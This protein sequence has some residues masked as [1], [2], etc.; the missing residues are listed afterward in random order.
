MGQHFLLTAAART[1]SLASVA[2]MSD[3]EARSTFQRIRWADNGGEPYCPKCGSTEHLYLPNQLRWKCRGCRHQYSVTSSTIF[4]NRKLPVRDYLLAIA[5]FVNGA[6]GYAALQL[7]RDLDCQYK[8][9][10]V[11]SHKLREAIE[12]E[13]RGVVLA[14]TVEVDGAYFGGHVRQ[15]NKAEDR[16]DRRLAEE[17][18]G[19]RQVV[20]VVRQRGGRTITG[21]FKRESEGVAVVRARVAMPAIVHADEARGWDTLH[22]HYDM[23]RVNHSVEFMSQQGACT[24]QAESFFSRL[25]RSEFGIHHRISGRYL[26][27]YAAE[28]GWR[29]DHRRVSN[30]EQWGVVAALALHHPISREWCGYWQRGNAR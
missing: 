11:L 16:A 23:R 30:G 14:G 9:A 8:T 7:S 6:K 20:V 24:N 29:E 19:K 4:A 10:F 17:Q 18:T 28:M 2:R 13:Q 5:I 21:V 3:E 26:H 27:R 25:R 22:A 1:L 15:E 12:A